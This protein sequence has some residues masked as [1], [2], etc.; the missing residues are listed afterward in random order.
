MGIEVFTN[1]VCHKILGSRE[2]D[3]K[4]RNAVVA[5]FAEVNCLW[6]SA[7]TEEKAI[8]C[9]KQDFKAQKQYSRTKMGI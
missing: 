9:T 7:A 5:I 4:G 1:Q 8:F 6:R 2:R 3:T